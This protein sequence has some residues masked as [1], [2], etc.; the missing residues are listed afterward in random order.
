MNQ[1]KAAGIQINPECG[2]SRQQLIDLLFLVD[3]TTYEII[4]FDADNV[5]CYFVFSYDYY[6]AKIDGENL[7]RFKETFIEIAN[8]MEKES[9]HD[10]YKFD[11]DLI[12]F[13]Y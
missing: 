8:D 4:S 1:Y 13:G 9:S 10:V 2:I 11:E 6:E 7:I 12:Y 3:D 5:I